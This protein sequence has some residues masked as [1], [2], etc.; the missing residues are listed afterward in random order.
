MLDNFLSVRKENTVEAEY[1]A[2]MVFGFKSTILNVNLTPVHVNDTE[3][4]NYV[5]TI[6]NFT[7]ISKSLLTNTKFT[8]VCVSYRN[9]HMWDFLSFLF[10]PKIAILAQMV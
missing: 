10:I 2:L 1:F 7:E 6:N 3:T 5:F 8:D 9:E 4:M